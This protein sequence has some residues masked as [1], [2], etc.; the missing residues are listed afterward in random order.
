L[1]PLESRC[2]LSTITEYQVPNIGESSASPQAITMAGGKIWF[3]ELGGGIGSIVPTNPSNVT[4]YSNGL[5]TGAQPNAITAGSDGN[6]WFAEPPLHQIGILNVSSPT[7]SIV[8]LG[9]AQGLPTT[10]LPT[11]ITSGPDGNIWVTDDANNALVMI[12]PRN[13]ST[14][15]PEISVPSSTN[16]GFLNF[17]S[18]IVSGPNGNLYFTEAKVGSG[19]AISSPAIGYYNPS[20]QKWGE[21]ALPGGQVP[22]GIAAGPNNTIWFSEVAPGSG[23]GFQ[24]SAI[25]VINV[26]AAPPTPVEIA[27][28]TP[29]GG[30]TVD[31]TT[32]VEGPD[33]QMY[34]TD[35]ANGSIGVV[36]V[37][38]NPSSDSITLLP[39]PT[40][41]TFPSPLPQGIT[42]GP[43]G[44][45]WFTDFHNAVGQV[46]LNAQIAIYT[47]PPSTV[48]TNVPFGGLIAVAT[49]VQTGALDTAFTGT[50]TA[51]LTNS[52]SDRLGGTT[53][54][55][56]QGGAAIFSNL[57]LSSAAS[58]LTLTLSTTGLS[59][60]SATTSSIN[61]VNPGLIF[62]YQPPSSV[63]LD[64]PFNVVVLAVTNTGV[65]DTYY[66]GAVA[67]GLVNSSGGS[68]SAT[69]S[70]PTTVTA[71]GGVA[72]F[73]GLSVNTP[74]PYYLE[75]AGIGSG[76][77]ISSALTVQP[78][79]LIFFYEPPTTVK[80]KN[81]FNVVVLAVLGTG[82]LDT[83]YNG[84]VSIGLV[85]S[86]SSSN[87]VLSG[88][89]TV[90]ASGGV[91]LFAGLNV[92]LAGVYYLDSGG[93]GASSALS[94]AFT[95]S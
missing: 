74:G 80:A 5:P 58:N 91:A 65:L 70:G 30:K 82:A 2:L 78:P 88:P 47:Q 56:A 31:P 93:I 52:G 76:V 11:G 3:S 60:P 33:G 44:N 18:Q 90:I 8:N 45:V 22:L 77:N 63:G 83:N 35:S 24:S 25:G 27:T 14:I 28:T 75:T 10:L 64:S 15:S 53:S 48:T 59:V 95:V 55:T 92:S 50:V 34:F 54:V 42:A 86:G 19:G 79:Q 46:A 40:N 89:T 85:P 71:S 37:T 94:T 51:A 87:G 72:L 29:S 13:T 1:E 41:S 84:A 61:V 67:I 66:N 68:T 43:D 7:S 17:A 4:S 26:M 6:I 20:T 16:V 32:I 9:S 38:S 23:G 39:I 49:Y 36:T 12:N 69:L 21:Y 81:T 57:T 62:F 73:A